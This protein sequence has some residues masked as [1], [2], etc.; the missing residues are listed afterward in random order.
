MNTYKKENQRKGAEQ[1]QKKESKLR[2]TEDV[3]HHSQQETI[4][5]NLLVQ[6]FPAK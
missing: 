6:I 2:K 3:E 1:K 5:L 4:S